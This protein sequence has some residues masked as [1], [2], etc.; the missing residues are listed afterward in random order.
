M[1]QSCFYSGLLAEK[2]GRSVKFDNEKKGQWDEILQLSD[3]GTIDVIYLS[4]GIFEWTWVVIGGVQLIIG[5]SLSVEEKT[6]MQ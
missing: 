4:I 5:D 6:I 2:R 3:G 1:I